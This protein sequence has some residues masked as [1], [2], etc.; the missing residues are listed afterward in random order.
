MRD[1]KAENGFEIV[2]RVKRYDGVKYLVV[3]NIKAL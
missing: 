2:T 3:E 1:A